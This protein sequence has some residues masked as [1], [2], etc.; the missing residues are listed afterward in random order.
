MRPRAALGFVLA[1]A[2]LIG[3]CSLGLSSRPDVGDTAEAQPAAPAD[4]TKVALLPA[5]AVQEPPRDLPGVDT[6]ALDDSRKQVFWDVAT[7]LY[8]PCSNQA[9]TLAQCVE[10]KRD[11]QACVPAANMLAVQVQRGVAKATA[12]AAVNARFAPDVVKVIDLAD[13]PSRGPVD[14]PITMVVFSDFE[15]P[16]CGATVP[17]LETLQ[18]KHAKEIRLVHK[19]YPL[20]KHTRAR[21]A[22]QAAAA[23]GKQGKYWE[24]EK[25]LFENQ[26]AL[27]D[28]DLDGYAEKL[29]LDMNRFRADKASPA[30]DAMIERDIKAG[31]EAGLRYTPFVLMNGRLFDT[32]FFKYDRDLEAW[33]AT[34]VAL[35]RKK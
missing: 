34:E 31:D 13:S 19:Y 30:I 21:A 33:I 1:V 7:R 17:F 29:E 3:G 27:Q 12:A 5:P 8:A 26:G 22:A 18:E 32:A 14:A 35:A 23:A 28:V 20:K 9:V 15:C 10:E 6:S 16:A 4:S 11:C 24:M 25:I 2:G